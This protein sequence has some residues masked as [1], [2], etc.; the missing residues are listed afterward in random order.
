MVSNSPVGSTSRLMF[1]YLNVKNSLL[2]SLKFLWSLK[3]K[4]INGVKLVYDKL[5]A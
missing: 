2:L 1:T 4:S 3:V 5:G